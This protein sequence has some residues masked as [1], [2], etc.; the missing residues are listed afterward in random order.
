MIGNIGTLALQITLSDD[1][2]NIMLA[3]L[4]IQI[5]INRGFYGYAFHSMNGIKQKNVNDILNH[6][7]AAHG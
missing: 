7:L 1:F 4:F 2:W 3:I 6:I 5:S